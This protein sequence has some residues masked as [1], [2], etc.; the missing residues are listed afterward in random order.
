MRNLIVARLGELKNST[1]GNGF[2]KKMMRWSHVEFYGQ[3][4]SEVDYSSLDDAKLL[5]FY[6]KI[7]RQMNK[8]MG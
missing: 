1:D 3:H 2:N 5:V 8:C 4:V 7:L 6:E